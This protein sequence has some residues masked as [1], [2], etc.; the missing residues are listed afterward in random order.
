[1]RVSSSGGWTSTINPHSKRDRRRS[2]SVTTIWVIG[3]GGDYDLFVLSVEGVE[4]VKE[5]LLGGFLSGEKLDVINQQNIDAAVLFTE[6]VV[7]W[8][9][10]AFMRSL[11]NSSDET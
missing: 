11:V 8:L 10:M 9:R 5:F 1:M 6:A 4:C 3:V 7:L 2:S